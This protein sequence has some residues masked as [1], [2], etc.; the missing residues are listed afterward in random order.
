MDILKE[1]DNNI[2]N[3]M[4]AMDFKKQTQKSVMDFKKQTQKSV[5]EL[6]GLINTL[7]LTNQLQSRII[8]KSSIP[9]KLMV[10]Y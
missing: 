5:Q 9:F 3:N 4:V 7:R 6:K 10:S 2:I 1:T 8:L